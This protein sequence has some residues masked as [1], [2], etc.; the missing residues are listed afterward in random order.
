MDRDPKDIGEVATTW[1]ARRVVAHERRR[2]RILVALD[3][4]ATAPSQPRTRTVTGGALACEALLA[5]GVTTLFGYPGGAALPFYR[6]LARYPR[7]R[8]VL[9]RHEQNAAHA[10]DGYARATGRVG[11]CVATSGPGATNLLTGLAT[12]FMDCVPV[13]ALTGQVARAAI[14]TQAFQEVD[15]LGM[16]GPIT[17]AAFQLERPEDIPRVVAEAVRIATSGRPGPVLID[18]PKDVQMATAEVTDDLFPAHET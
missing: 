17:K 1:P 8:H 4:P 16:V 12:A 15:V 3:T 2:N 10:A 7:L 5:A 14:G 9:V 18:M 6:E 11:V 13:V